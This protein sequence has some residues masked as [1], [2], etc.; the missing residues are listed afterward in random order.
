MAS[1]EPPEL[2]EL[3]LNAF[4][5]QDD[6]SDLDFYGQPRFVHHIDERAIAALT[7]FYGRTLPAGGVILDLM[8]SW[9]SHL[10]PDAAYAE[11][12]GHG[13]NARELAANPRLD[14]WFVQDLNQDPG[15]SLADAS[16][17]GA[18]ICVA[19]QYL[20]RPV[21]VLEQLSRA[22]KPGAPVVISFSN[23]CFPTKA[24]AVWRALDETGHAR[25]IDL[26]LRRAG[27]SEVSVEPLAWDRPGDP[28][29]AVVGRRR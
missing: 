6:G 14:R 22:L 3:P 28:L 10:P 19:V 2:P 17:D 27:F 4:D 5:R 8:S 13:M 26:Y 20:Q 15:L 25:L 12:I 23:R 18:T 11:V 24:V 21:A 9:V 29:T 7:A 16:L 1:D